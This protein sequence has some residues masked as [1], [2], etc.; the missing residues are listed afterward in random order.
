N[1]VSKNP[2]DGE[3]ESVQKSINEFK[4]R[5]SLYTFLTSL[6]GMDEMRGRV[7][8]A[9]TNHIERID[10]ALL[11]PGRFD[12]KLKLE[13]FTPQETKELLHKM[14]CG[15]DD[16]DLIDKAKFPHMKYTPVEIVNLCHVHQS[17]KDVIREMCYEPNQVV[18]KSTNS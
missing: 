11:R 2:I 15:R 10:P 18:V 17:L 14:F 4:D 1:K 8:I 5:L 6:D 9:T 16:E 12:L 7:M 13:E 3:I